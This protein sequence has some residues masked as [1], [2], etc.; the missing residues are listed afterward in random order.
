[1]SQEK[2]IEVESGSLLMKFFRED[3]SHYLDSLLSGFIH[4]DTPERMR[5]CERNGVGDTKDSC[6]MTFRT[7]RDDPTEYSLKLNGHSFDFDNGVKALTIQNKT[8]T[9]QSWMNC[10]FAFKLPQNEIDAELLKGHLAKMKRDFGTRYVVLSNF[11][12]L[13]ERLQKNSVKPVKWGYVDYSS[14]SYDWN[15]LCKSMDYSYQSE[16]RFLFGECALHEKE[17]YQFQIEEGLHDI[18]HADADIKVHSKDTG[19]LWLDLLAIKPA[20]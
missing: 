12:L 17:P 1:M 19:K 14:S 10:W 5:L 2:V 13:I 9:N 4:N 18:L 20:E 16:F 8:A 7:E 3:S 15:L 6:V 11:K